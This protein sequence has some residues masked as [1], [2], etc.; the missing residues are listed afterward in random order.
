MNEWQS[1]SNTPHLICDVLLSDGMIVEAVC[2]DGNWEI[3]GGRIV[4]PI[5]YKAKCIDTFTANF[6]SK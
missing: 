4:Y 2:I 6:W 5:A 1:T 3:A